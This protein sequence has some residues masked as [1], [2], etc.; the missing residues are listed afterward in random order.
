MLT[1]SIA[2]PKSMGGPVSRQARRMAEPVH[3]GASSAQET[4]ATILVFCR[5]LR[6]EL[7]ALLV[8]AFLARRVVSPR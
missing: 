8:E 2:T 3:L 5:A 1:E 4:L 7:A 6:Q